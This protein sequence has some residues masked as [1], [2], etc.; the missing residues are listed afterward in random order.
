ME[1]RRRYFLRRLFARLR[2]YLD[3]LDP[4]EYC[5]YTAKK[6]CGPG[7]CSLRWEW[8]AARHLLD[9]LEEEVVG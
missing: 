1:V 9:R 4:C 3:S 6:L 5:D 7:G 2:Q 8:R